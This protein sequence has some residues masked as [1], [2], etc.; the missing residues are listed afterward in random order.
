MRIIINAD[1]CGYSQTVNKHIEEAIVQRRISSTTIMAN[2]DDFDG[3]ID[4]YGKHKDIA[5][6]GFHL[7]LTEGEPLLK[8]DLLL[9]IGFYKEENDKI[10][11]NGNPFRRKFLNKAIREEIYKE[12]LAQGMKIKDAGVELS[13]IDSHHFMHQAVFMI[14]LLPRLCKD[15]GVYKVRNYRNYMPKSINRML[16]KA[17]SLLLKFQCSKLRFTDF[18]DEYHNFYNLHIKGVHYCND[19]VVELMC[20]PGGIYPE[21][22]EILMK[23]DP[24]NLFKS[25]LIS[26]NQL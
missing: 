15:L 24:K 26:Y 9:R 14:P 25:N 23:N 2:M 18:F 5:S 16:R 6:F 10:V 11:L 12:I 1:D 22:E 17:W 13:H 19:D 3:A 8:S 20:H 21:E 4:M 7:N